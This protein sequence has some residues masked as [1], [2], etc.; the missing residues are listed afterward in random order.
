ML[1]NEIRELAVSRRFFAKVMFD[2]Y[3]KGKGYEE[4][5]EEIGQYQPYIIE[6]NLQDHI[7]LELKKF[8]DYL[9]KHPNDQTKEK[10]L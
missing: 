4:T 10:D 9:K 3:Q 7:E 8:K 6:N 1:V 2:C 5:V